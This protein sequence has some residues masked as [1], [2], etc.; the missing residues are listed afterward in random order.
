MPRPKLSPTEEQRR[1]VKTM[2]AMGATQEEVAGRIGVRSPKTLRKYF[3]KELDQGSSEANMTVAQ[4]LYNEAKGG[5]VKAAMFWLKCRA[6]WRDRAEFEPAASP[7]APFIVS[8][9]KQQP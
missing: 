7:A 4:A 1:M 3:R 2:K 6:G 8:Y 5:D 9:E